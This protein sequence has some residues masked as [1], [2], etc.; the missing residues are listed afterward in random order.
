MVRIK[1]CGTTNLKDAYAAVE[2]GADA[3]GFVFYP[4]SPRAVTPETVKEIISKLPPFITTVGVFVDE[5]P[6]EIE[7]AVN[8]AGLDVVQLHGSEPPESSVFSR[9]VIKAIRVKDLTDLEPL[10][11]YRSV[12]AFLLDAYAPDIPGGTG[13]VFNWDIALEAKKFGRIILA[14]GLMPD[15]VADAIELVRPYGVDA[16]T[17]VEGNKKGVK[18][19][20][21]LRLFIERAQQAIKRHV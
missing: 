7:K 2:F 20:K 19:H 3:L 4:K 1:I 13:Q 16:V 18:D 12:S 10:I 8:Y 15:N 6:S 9:K 5:K 14:G 11:T 21:K 17:G